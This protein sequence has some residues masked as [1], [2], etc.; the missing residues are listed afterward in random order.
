[1]INQVP[2]TNEIPEIL[3]CLSDSNETD[4]VNSLIEIIEFCHYTDFNSVVNH[5][6]KIVINS[7]VKILENYY[8][9]IT[10]KNE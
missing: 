2:Y 1:M 6:S 5:F 4:I 10:H 8:E 3:D 9:E 7:N